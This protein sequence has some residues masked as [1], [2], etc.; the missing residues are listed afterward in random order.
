MLGLKWRSDAPPP[1]VVPLARDAYMAGLVEAEQAWRWIEQAGAWAHAIFPTYEAYLLN[2]RLGHAYWSNDFEQVLARRRL[3][4]GFVQAKPRERWPMHDI[5]WAGDTDPA[6]LP[7]AVRGGLP[8]VAPP[9]PLGAGG[10]PML[11]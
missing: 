9:A 1:R 11:N 3:I 8:P 7:P 10:G 6:V 2:L 4:E 5:G